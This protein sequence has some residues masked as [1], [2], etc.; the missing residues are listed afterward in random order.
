MR[1][2]AQSGRITPIQPDQVNAEHQTNR[3]AES[4]QR[5]GDDLF[6]RTAI[7]NV[8]CGLYIDHAIV[9]GYV[10]GSQSRK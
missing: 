7:G 10:E 3:T 9:F 6:I 8:V 1:A 4:I 5:R 2:R